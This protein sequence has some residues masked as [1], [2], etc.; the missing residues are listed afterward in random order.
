MCVVDIYIYEGVSR[1]AS[2]CFAE[3]EG[4]K[5]KEVNSEK[6]F[7][8]MYEM[9]RAP[10]IQWLNTG[11]HLS[12]SNDNIGEKPPSVIRRRE[13]NSNSQINT[14]TLGERCNIIEYY[15]YIRQRANCFSTCRVLQFTKALGN[16]K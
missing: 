10:S 4:E 1:G 2:G 13:N 11:N 8:E 6:G 14:F 5:Q 3:G 16:R 9:E 15:I 12:L 7:S